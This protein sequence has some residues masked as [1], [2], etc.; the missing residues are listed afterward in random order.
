MSSLLDEPRDRRRRRTRAAVLDAAAEL[1]SRSGFRGTSVD[2]IAAHADVALTSLY[3]NFPDGK[4]EVYAVVA[5]RLARDHAE[6]MRRSVEGTGGGAQ[7]ARAA[8]EEY[9][10]FHR[11][12]PL[13][14]R[15]LGLADVSAV[16]GDVVDQARSEIARVLVGVADDVIDAIDSDDPSA[17]SSVL[18]AWAAINGVLALEQRGHIDAATSDSLLADAVELHVA[19]VAQVS[20][21]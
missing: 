1:F 9:A 3:G 6:R 2:A 13:A 21:V 14:F 5:C 7:T 18:L 17:R 19:R 10:R 15:M 20:D 4:A 11:D 12:E 16:H 8:F